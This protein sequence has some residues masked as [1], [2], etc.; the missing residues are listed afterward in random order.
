MFTGSR[1][2]NFFNAAKLWQS[3]MP[4]NLWPISFSTGSP[5]IVAEGLNLTFNTFKPL[6]LNAVLMNAPFIF[7][8]NWRGVC[9]Y[10]EKIIFAA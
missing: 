6:W 4:G 1:Q 3:A 7:H 2:S 9:S 10:S 8:K 5:F